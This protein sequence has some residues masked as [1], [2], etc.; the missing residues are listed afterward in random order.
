MRKRAA[1]IAIMLMVSSA[2]MAHREEYNSM[3]SQGGNADVVVDLPPEVWTQNQQR[4]QDDCQRCCTYENR[5]YSE[6]S[7]VK[8][9]GIIL[10][11]SRDEKSLGT[12][13]LIWKVLK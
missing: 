1:A 13:N 2:A 9:E 12:N 5:R 3:P 4:Q 11:C 10:Q 6:G 7:L 8:A